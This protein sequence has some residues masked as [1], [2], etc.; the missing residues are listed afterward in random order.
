MGHN[1]RKENTSRINHDYKV[2][3]KVLLQKP[4]EHLGKLE[5]PR[6]GPHTAQSL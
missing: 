5:A 6:T 4:G 2:G 3:E 1:N